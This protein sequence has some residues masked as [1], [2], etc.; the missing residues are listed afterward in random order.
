MT[1]WRSKSWCYAVF[2]HLLPLICILFTF[3]FEKSS[4]HLIILSLSINTRTKV[5]VRMFFFFFYEYWYVK[6]LHFEYFHF[7]VWKSLY[8]GF[9]SPIWMF[10]TDVTDDHIVIVHHKSCNHFNNYHKPLRGFHHG[11]A[12]S[13]TR[14]FLG[15][16]LYR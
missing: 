15:L 9:F 16:R 13:D 10:F 1:A 3:F 7:K 14:N 11:A 12:L 8:Q 4:I 2:E 6:I 5:Q